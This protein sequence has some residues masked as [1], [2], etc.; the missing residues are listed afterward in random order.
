MTGYDGMELKFASHNKV[1]YSEG[2]L[3]FYSSYLVGH[4][5]QRGCEAHKGYC[6]AS[7]SQV[8]LIK[9]RQ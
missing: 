2:S 1:K 3:Y 7:N 4:S 8:M 5:T 6:H 9:L